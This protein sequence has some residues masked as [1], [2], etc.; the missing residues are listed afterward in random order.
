MRLPALS[1]L[2]LLATAVLLLDSDLCIRYAN[3]AAENLFQLSNQH[4]PEGSI[5]QVFEGAHALASTAQA[6]HAR[7]ATFT[8]HDV[9]LVLRPGQPNREELRLDCA[10]TPVTFGE[11]GVL[12]EFKLLN[13]QLKAARE[14][15]A[16]Q[17]S[18]LNRELVRNLAHEIR[19][20]LGGI[21]GAAQL[22]ENELER[23]DLTE[24]TRVIIKEADRLQGLLDRLLTPSRLPKTEWLN[25]HEVLEQVRS[26]ILAEFP[27]GLRVRRDYDPSLPEVRADKQ[28]MTQAFLNIVRNAAQ[29]CNSV[30]SADDSSSGA[31]SRS[32]SEIVLRTRAV[33]RVT[34][35]KISH[36]LALSVQ[37]IDN[38]PGI[39]RDIQ[40][41]IFFPLFSAREGG[42]GLGLTIAQSF[43]NQQGGSIEVE[44]VPG[45]TCFTVTLP[46]HH[47]ASETVG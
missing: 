20:P 29:A 24:Y 42:T 32:Q 12:I 43:V 13:Q 31:P 34:L 7:G 44:S 23:K 4:L 16:L 17:E 15:R 30:G 39:A 9:G 33:R 10:C 28:Q 6:A 41:K 19:N 46:A 37:V 36:R 11:P 35:A 14:E 22:L 2:D 45:R 1:G 26:L 21:R 47:G 27:K 40:E 18:Q 3:A 38:G 5:T 25:V 8:E